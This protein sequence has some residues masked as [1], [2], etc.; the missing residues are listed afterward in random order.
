MTEAL[1]TTRERFDQI[2]AHREAD[3]VPVVDFPWDSTLARW[4]TR[5]H[6]SRG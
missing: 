6:A 5:G 4:R 2:F 1:M 3:R